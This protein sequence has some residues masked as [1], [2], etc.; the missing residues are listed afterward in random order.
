MQNIKDYLNKLSNIKGY[1]SIKVYDECV[2]ITKTITDDVK[3]EKMNKV[4]SFLNTNKKTIMHKKER[5]ELKT[6]IDNVLEP[7]VITHLE[8]EDGT[9]CPISDISKMLVQLRRSGRLDIINDT[10]TLIR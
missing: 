7:E 6:L 8:L 3:R 1:I 10:L 5:D 2:S 4:V 9:L